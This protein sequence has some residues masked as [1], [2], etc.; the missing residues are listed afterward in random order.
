M[1]ETKR[2]DFCFLKKTPVL[3]QQMHITRSFT[4]LVP[5]CLNTIVNYFEMQN[6]NEEDKFTDQ[7]KQ[8]F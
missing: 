5:S 6:Q 2:P 4:T 1:V 7:H 3:L 8:E